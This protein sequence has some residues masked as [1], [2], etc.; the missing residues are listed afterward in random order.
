MRNVAQDRA[1]AQKLT[2]TVSCATN[3]QDILRKEN[4]MQK[5]PFE[6]NGITCLETVDGEEVSKTKG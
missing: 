1:F 5:S 6:E 4:V 3:N 2:L